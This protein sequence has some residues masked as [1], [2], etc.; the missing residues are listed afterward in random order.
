MEMPDTIY[1]GSEDAPFTCPFDGARTNTVE[2]DGR[3]FMERCLS[4]NKIFAFD[5]LYDEED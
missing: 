4:C 5:S 1:G 3:I 2:T